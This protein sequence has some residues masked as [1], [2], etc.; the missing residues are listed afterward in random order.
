MRRPSVGIEAVAGR[1]ASVLLSW[2]RGGA[3]GEEEEP[4]LEVVKK[5]ESAVAGVGSSSGRDWLRL[6]VVVGW[7]MQRSDNAICAWETG[8]RKS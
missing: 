8:C 6:M 4:W 5:L 1:S 3:G 7:F 2:L